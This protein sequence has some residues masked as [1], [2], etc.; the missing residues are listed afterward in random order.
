M[1]KKHH[2]YICLREVCTGQFCVLM[3][4]LGFKVRAGSHCQCQ[5]E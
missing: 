5:E 2:Y 1:A 4:V 3:Q